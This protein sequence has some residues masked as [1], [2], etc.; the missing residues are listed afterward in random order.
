MNEKGI[1]H[2][3]VCNRTYNERELGWVYRA[4]YKVYTC[5]N[6]CYTS[7]KENT[8]VVMGVCFGERDGVKKLL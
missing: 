3:C 2:C 5:S 7:V 1:A 4:M 8:R 6:E